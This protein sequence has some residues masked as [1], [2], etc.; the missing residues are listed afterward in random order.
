MLRGAELLSKAGYTPFEGFRT[1]GGI[2]KV[3]LRGSLQVDGGKVTAEKWAN[4]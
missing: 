3:Y 2:A 1:N 4:I